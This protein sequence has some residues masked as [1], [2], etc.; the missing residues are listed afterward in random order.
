[1]FVVCTSSLPSP[2][3][4]VIEVTLLLAVKEHPC[5]IS[6]RWIIHNPECMELL[7]LNP[8][9]GSPGFRSPRSGVNRLHLCYTTLNT[10]STTTL[11]TD[12]WCYCLCVTAPITLSPTHITLVSPSPPP[13]L[14]VGLLRN[15]ELLGPTC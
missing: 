11:K 13:I 1:M 15:T 7:G 8:P 3:A 12:R 2:P 9:A 14:S 10:S 5:S 4:G 6:D